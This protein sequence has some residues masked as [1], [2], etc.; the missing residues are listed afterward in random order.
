[1]AR[2]LGIPQRE[3]RYIFSKELLA[4]LPESVIKSPSPH[5]RTVKNCRID[6]IAARSLLEL[7]SDYIE[8]N[9]MGK[10]TLRVF[11][12]QEAT[13]RAVDFE[14]LFRAVLESRVQP[15]GWDRQMGLLGLKFESRDLLAC[16]RE[17]PAKRRISE[18]EMR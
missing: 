15:A 1:V 5:L 17:R 3:V 11:D 9:S 12:F 2:V 8:P 4:M 16:S 10:V 14:G 13:N 18:L 7:L 6:S